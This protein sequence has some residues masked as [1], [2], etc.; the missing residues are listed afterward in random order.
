LRPTQHGV[1]VA[2]DVWILGIG[3]GLVFDALTEDER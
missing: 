2:K 1:A 3:L